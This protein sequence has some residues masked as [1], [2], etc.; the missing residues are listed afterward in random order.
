MRNDLSIAADRA[1]ETVGA[2]IKRRRI[3]R[4]KTQKELAVEAG[5]NQGYLSLIERDKAKPRRPT[6]DALAVAFAD[7]APTGVVVGIV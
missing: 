5:I 7:G 6:F 2:R 1:A 3:E 4:G